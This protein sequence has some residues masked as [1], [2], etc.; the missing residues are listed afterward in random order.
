VSNG[1]DVP[2]GFETNVAASHVTTI[3]LV[4]L[5]LDSGT[6]YMTDAPHDVTYDGQTWQSMYGVAGVSDLVETDGEV[7]G[8]QFQISGV[9]TSLLA[10]ALDEKIQGRY[11]TVKLA[12]LANT[13]LTVDDNAWSGSLDTMQIVYDEDGQHASIY[14]TAEHALARWDQPNLLRYSHQDQQRLHPGDMFFE[15]AE[16][17]AE[18]TVTW[19]SAEFF[20]K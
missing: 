12:T 6:L 17:M 9:P 13:T 3:L 15:F 14:V 16:R 20:K 4:Q 10:L 1:R 18:V 19:P 7:R 2:A 5:D 8:L 11:V